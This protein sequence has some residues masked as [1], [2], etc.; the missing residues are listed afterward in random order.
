LDREKSTDTP[1]KKLPGCVGSEE[2]QVFGVGGKQHQRTQTGRT[3]RV[4]LGDGLG[5]VANSVKRVRGGAHFRRQVSHLGNAARVV[6]HRTEGVE[7]HN[8]TGQ[9]QHG[10]HG[11]GNAEQACKRIGGNDATDD[12]QRRN[13]GCFQRDCQ[14][15]DD[16]G[17]VT[18]DRCLA[19]ERTGR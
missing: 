15:L 7:C 9:R 12:D 19:I 5:G 17:A 2:L 13:G 1:S 18:G 16:V 8:H 6:R 14:T 3:D 10:G 4:A 11:N